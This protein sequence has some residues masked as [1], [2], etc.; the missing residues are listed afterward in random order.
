[1]RCVPLKAG[2]EAIDRSDR[3][4]QAIVFAANTGVNVMDVSDA[5]LGLTP[6]VAAAIDYAYHKGMVI[7]WASNDFESADHTDGMFY[8][9]VWPGNSLTGDHSTRN[10]ATCP[11][12]PSSSTDAYCLFVS[13]NT[14]FA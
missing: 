1:C 13:S 5:S 7:A 8:P 11:V 10:S 3:V 4:A 9:H 14:T 6:V 12:P 2:D